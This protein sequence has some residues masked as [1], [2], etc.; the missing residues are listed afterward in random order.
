[1]GQNECAFGQADCGMSRIYCDR[2][3][4]DTVQSCTFSE[5]KKKAVF[6]I[7]SLVY[8][9]EI[10]FRFLYSIYYH[11]QTA[12]NQPRHPQHQFPPPKN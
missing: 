12:R 5:Q 9:E 7:Y 1:M 11:Y 3:N 10:G 4:R 6:S 2:V 8:P